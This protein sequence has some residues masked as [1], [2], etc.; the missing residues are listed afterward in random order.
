MNEWIDSALATATSLPGAEH[1]AVVIIR[2]TA[3]ANIRWANNALTTNGQ[4]HRVTA[5]VVAL[6]QVEGGTASGCLEGPVGSAE[7][8]IDLLRRAATV[9][10]A[11]SPDEDAHD[12]PAGSVDDDFASAGAPC[13]IE[14]FTAVS[15]GLGRAFQ[16]A[17]G[18]HL[19]FGFAELV[20]TTTWLG[21]SAGARRRGVVRMGR[22]E[23]NAKHPDMVGSA[24]VGRSSADFTDVDID[25]CV[26][27]V[28]EQLSWNQN[29]VELPAGRYEVILPPGAVTDLWVYA[30]WMSAGREAREGQTAFAGK[31]GATRVG[32]RL[33]AVPLSISSDPS[34]AGVERLPFVAAG[35]SVAGSESVYDNGAEVGPITWLDRGV[36]NTLVETSHEQRANGLSGP[37]PYP[38][39]NL[40]IEAESQTSLDEMI[41]S[42]KRGLLLTCLWYIRI[43]DPET[44]LMT[45]LTRDGVYLIEDGQV[46]G[47]VN[48][49]RWNES[50]VSLLGRISEVGKA[51][52]NLCREW[53]DYFQLSIAP[54]VRVPDFNMSTVSKAF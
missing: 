32:E 17:E 12:L 22:L 33:A 10:A 30:Y 41:A 49:F 50:P 21:T 23:L 51:E 46:V 45:G 28:L 7:D 47:A 39:E 31:D 19:F 25:A 48:N 37:L 44:L 43:V 11:G 54:P 26:A 2:E 20:V 36:L 35:A 40:V 8:V 18:K 14:V 29:R 4:M 42:T 27:Q 24:W 1:G 16:D 15:E 6:A 38:T 13:G 53:N 9:A 52:R 3:E 5:E 34:L